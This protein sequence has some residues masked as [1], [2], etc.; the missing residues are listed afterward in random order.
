MTWQKC[1]S[2]LMLCC[3][4]QNHKGGVSGSDLGKLPALLLNDLIPEADVL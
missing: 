4:P 2:G 3:Y 1:A